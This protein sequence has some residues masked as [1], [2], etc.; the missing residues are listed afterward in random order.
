MCCVA[1]HR[2]QCRICAFVMGT[3]LR[4]HID[5]VLM[6]SCRLCNS[7]MCAPSR[8][9]RRQVSAVRCG[10]VDSACRGKGGTELCRGCAVLTG[11]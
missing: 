9:T 1:V 11:S 8:Y 10:V 5:K 7:P 2:K 4:K 6:H 3:H